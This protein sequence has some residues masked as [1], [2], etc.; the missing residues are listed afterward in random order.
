[1]SLKSPSELVAE[2]KAAV[3]R[4]TPAEAAEIL[5]RTPDVLLLDVR[6]PEEHARGSVPGAVLLPRGVLEMRIGQIC[7]DPDR[8]ILVHCAAGGRAALAARTL[9]EM[10]YRNVRCVDGPFEELARACGP[11]AS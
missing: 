4:C 7:D 6:E 5:R 11:G 3:A 1:M 8:P 2:A 9:K 10:G